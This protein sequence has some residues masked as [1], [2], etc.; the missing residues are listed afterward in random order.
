[1]KKSE[2]QGSKRKLNVNLPAFT[3]GAGKEFLKDAFVPKS[4]NLTN[5]IV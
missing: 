1:M 2:S 5:F 3:P 4:M